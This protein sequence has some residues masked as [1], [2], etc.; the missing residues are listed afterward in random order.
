MKVKDLGEVRYLLGIEERRRQQFGDIHLGDILLVQE[1]YVRDMLVRYEMIDCKP[2]NTPLEPNVKMSEE[3]CP[4]SDV[5]K[6]EMAQLPYRSVVGSLMYLSVCT[7]PDICQAVSE[8]SRFNNNPGK[9]HWESAKR[10]LRYLKGSSGVGL[11]YKGGVS[12]DLW[13]YVDASHASCPDIGKGRAGYV[14]ISAGAAVSWSSKRLGSA[15][16]SSC[17]SEYMGLTLAAQEASFL[18][19]LKGEMDGVEKEEDGK[20]IRILTDSQYAKVWLR[21]LSTTEG[22]NTSWPS[23]TL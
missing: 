6:E 13:G 5:E 2:A 17:E 20:G 14:F 18:S 12:A 9:V 15:S 19:Q 16:L 4:S 10:V 22:A 7:R 3:D 11:L 23:G 21:A 8:L 1:K